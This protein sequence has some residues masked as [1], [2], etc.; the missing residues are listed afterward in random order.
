MKVIQLTKNNEVIKEFKTGSM[1]Q[2]VLPKTYLTWYNKDN[3]HQGKTE[4]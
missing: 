2:W 3:S 1:P 4:A